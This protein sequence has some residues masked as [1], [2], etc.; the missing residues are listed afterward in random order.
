MADYLIWL[1]FNDFFVTEKNKIEIYFIK[2]PRKY[3]SKVGKIRLLDLKRIVK[4][5]LK[6]INFNLEQ[7]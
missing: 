5:D 4:D 6:L 2:D 3:F 7:L 1:H